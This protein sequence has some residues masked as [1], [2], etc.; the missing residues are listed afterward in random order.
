MRER[1]REKIEEAVKNLF[2]ILINVEVRKPEEEKFGEYSTNVAYIL[3]KQVKRNP[4][5]IA[6][7]LKS[8]LNIKGIEKIEVIKG[9]MNFY[10]SEGV[11]ISKFKEAIKNN[12]GSS[13]IGKNESVNV[14]FVSANP[15]GPLHI[16]SA[17]AAAFGDTLVGLLSYLGFKGFAEYYVNDGGKQ[18][19]LLG[20]SVIARMKELKGDK[21][22]M[23]EDGYFGD[24]IKDIA[25]EAIKK[26]LKEEEVCAFTVEKILEMQKRSLDNFRVHFDQF[27][28]EKKLRE[29]KRAEEIINKLKDKKKLFFKDGALWYKGRRERVFVKS[30]GEYTYIVPDIAYHTYKFERGF[31]HL[32]DLL[33]PDHIAHIPELKMALNDLGYSGDE[34]EV[35]IIQQVNLLRDGELIKMSKRGGRF[36]T[37]DELIEDVGIDPARFFFLMRKSSTPLDFDINLALEKSERNPVYYVQYAH[38]RISSLLDFANEKGY[39]EVNPDGLEKLQKEEEKRI[40]KHI[41]RFPDFLADITLSRDLHLLPQYLIDTANLYH[42]FYQKNRVIGGEKEKVIPRLFLSAVVRNILKIGLTLLGVS[43]PERM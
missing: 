39:K 28:S 31:T 17:R 42:N 20:K 38:A 14:E 41:Y 3:A 22:E 21:F 33:G 29:G 30:D 36:I 13:N 11:Y 7:S 9:F 12:F 1:I 18:V 35:I 16:A 19:D 24:Y 34:L 37:M 32:I 8:G 6:E 27:T 4:N 26:N 23:P 5:E 15:T 43:A 2:N 25:R 40:I 10:L